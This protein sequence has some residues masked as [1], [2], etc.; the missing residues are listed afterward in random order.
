MK[1]LDDAI[2]AAIDAAEHDVDHAESIVNR[3]YA[4]RGSRKKFFFLFNQNLRRTNMQIAELVSL[5]RI[6]ARC[7]NQALNYIDITDFAYV[8]ELISAC[9]KGT[10]DPFKTGRD[11]ISRLI[12]NICAN[13]ILL[14]SYYGSSSVFI[15]PHI[16]IDIKLVCG[17]SGYI[18]SC[19][20]L[21]LLRNA[22]KATNQ[23]ICAALEEAEI[24]YKKEKFI[25]V[26][27]CH[28]DFTATD[29]GKSQFYQYG[30]DDVKLHISKAHVGAARLID[31]LEAATAER[32]ED[33]F[34]APG[35]D[36]KSARSSARDHFGDDA[37]KTIWVLA[38]AAVTPQ[39]RFPGEAKFYAI[40]LQIFRN[41]NYYH[42][43]DENKPDRKSVV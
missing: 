19:G 27:Y 33:F 16:D 14:E 12:H 36:Y 20:H 22:T 30:L 17:E 24:L 26:P 29:R 10:P 11:T 21:L 13:R 34:L 25:V 18:H 43:F 1:L 28:E 3:I 8:K 4:E 5:L 15:P 41:H 6:H 42:L 9:I 2:N 31:V 35:G 23:D 37:G 38:D 39:S 40:Y 32:E 7:K